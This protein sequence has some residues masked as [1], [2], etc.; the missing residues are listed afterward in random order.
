MKS[1]AIAVA[2]LA[3]FQQS[4]GCDQAK[5]TPKPAKITFPIHRFERPASVAPDIALDTL[6]GQYCKTW[7]W[8]YKKSEL[9]PTADLQD[10]PTCLSLFTS[11]P[12]Q[13]IDFSSITPI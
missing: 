3:L 11:Y 5:P 10:L 2:S 1:I 8:K 6:T 13:Q 9:A 12:S 4:V 7:E